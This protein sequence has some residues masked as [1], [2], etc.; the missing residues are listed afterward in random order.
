MKYKKFSVH[1]IPFR[2]GLGDK[3]KSNKLSAFEFK[4]KYDL[5]IYETMNLK[6]FY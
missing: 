3:Q 4:N 2:D 6:F 5:K 1:I